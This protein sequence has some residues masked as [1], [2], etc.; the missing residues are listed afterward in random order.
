ER[1]D[2]ADV[3][4]AP[5]GR[6][7]RALH[8]YLVAKRQMLRDVA[9]RAPAREMP[10]VTLERRLGR[11]IGHGIVARGL[12]AEAHAGILPGGKAERLAGQDLETHA[13]DVVGDADEA[14]HA[15]AQ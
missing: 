8:R 6:A 5:I 1:Q 14:R 11:H 4:R 10:D 13:L 9:R 2:G 15:A 7:E 12:A 3:A